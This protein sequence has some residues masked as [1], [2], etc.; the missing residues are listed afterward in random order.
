MGD[1]T[2]D[3]NDQFGTEDWNNQWSSVSNAITESAT[4]ADQLKAMDWEN[5]DKTNLDATTMAQ[6]INKMGNMTNEMNNQ[7]GSESWDSQWGTVSGSI[8]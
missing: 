2:V 4:V 1:M 6:L 3:M 5:I 8:D 7:F